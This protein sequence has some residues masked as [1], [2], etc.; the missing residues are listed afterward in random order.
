LCHGGGGSKQ[1]A[2]GSGRGVP[3]HLG[4]VGRLQDPSAAARAQGEAV[5]GVAEYFAGYEGGG[6]GRPQ[7]RPH[8]HARVRLVCDGEGRQEVS[9]RLEDKADDQ[10]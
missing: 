7:A 9:G 1:T 4:H 2:N 3:A 5:P 6:S 8:V 10:D